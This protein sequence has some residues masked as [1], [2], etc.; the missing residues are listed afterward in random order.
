MVTLKNTKEEKENLFMTNELNNST[1]NMLAQNMPSINYDSGEPMVS[2]RELHEG[3]E[4]KTAFKDWFPRITEYGFENGKDF[5]PLK[6]EQVRLEGVRM[7]R[8]EITDYQITIDMAKQI[9]M[10]QRS[11]KGK[12]YRKYFLA[13]EKIWNSP[14]QVMARGLQIANKTIENLKSENQILKDTIENQDR[15][16]EQKDNEISVQ[17]DQIKNKDKVINQKKKVIQDMKPKAKFHD[18]VA[19]SSVTKEEA[20][21]VRKFA[22]ILSQSKGIKIG[23]NKLFEFLRRYGYLCEASDVWNKPKQRMIDGGYM[24]YKEGWDRKTHEPTYHPL[25]TGKGQ[26]LFSKRVSEH[27]DFFDKNNPF[28]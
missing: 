7:V 19:R 6:K 25:I 16:I 9:C 12:L 1:T 2:A 28:Y 8:R 20:I 15:L 22:G 13:L 5:K 26:V 11:E 24:L 18:M 3:L 27:L 4:I 14:E 10:I 21:S 17:S 23:P